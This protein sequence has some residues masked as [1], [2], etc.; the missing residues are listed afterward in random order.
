[1]PLPSILA[2]HRFRGLAAAGVAAALAVATPQASSAA[3]GQAGPAAPQEPSA[4]VAAIPTFVHLPADQ[5]AHPGV[6][7]EWWYTVGQVAA[8]GHKFGYEVQLTSSGVTE[9]AINDITSGR[10]YSQQV[11]N[12]P[13]TFSASTTQL[14]VRMPNATLSGPMNAMHLTAT[15][16]GGTL[17]LTLN[18]RGAPMYENGTGLIPVLGGSSY[19]Y[20]LPNLETSG[21]VTVDGKASK[22]TG[23]SWLDRQWGQWDWSQLRKWTW[24]SIQLHNG[25]SISLSDL[26]SAQGEQHWATVLHPDG[27]ESVVSVN[28]LAKGA[29]DF[30]TSPTTG[31]RYAGKWTVEIPSLAKRGRTTLTVTATPTLQEIQAGLP[32]TPGINEAA[33]TV[34]GTVDG[35]HVTGQAYVEQ[36]GIW[37]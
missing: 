33:S 31:Q 9:I 6:G 17:D 15:L 36:F 11:M 23:K 18:A 10:Y 14:D 2:S 35:T 19:Y 25:D 21:T 1:M 8:H 5:A 16:P 37:K 4:P 20:S 22:I 3:T 7:E 32:F 26:Y 28:P 27:S 34:T 13:G 29:T 12:K 30:Q 24:M